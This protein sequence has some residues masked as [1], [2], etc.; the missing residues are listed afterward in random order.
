MR[1]TWKFLWTHPLLK[2]RPLYA[3]GRFFFWQ[4]RSRLWK[5]PVVFAW[6]G[7]SKLWIRGGWSSLT[8]N[9]YAGLYDF[10]DMGF[11]LHFLRPGDIF[12]DVGANMGSYSILAS[13][14]CRARS[15][16]YEPVPAAFGR[17]LAN[18]DLNDLSA[19]VDC[20][21]C[22][23]GAAPG[24]IS[25][26]SALDATNHVVSDDDPDR[27]KVQVVALDEDL[28]ETPILMKID[29]EGFE[30]EVLG[31]ARRLLGDPRLKAIVIELNGSG[32]RYGRNDADIHA[33]LLAAGFKAYHYSPQGRSLTPLARPGAANTLYCRDLMLVEERLRTAA[34]FTAAGRSF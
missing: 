6:V 15:V 22:A 27:M 23:V 20:R 24:V 10:E 3:F 16:S 19:L 31:G 17:L 9:Y 18:R 8:G 28:P 5:H 30:S 29:V 12:A 13:G 2:G 1:A 14:V 33:L 4:L 25:M 11:L 7:G 34:A 32:R 26:T 21:A